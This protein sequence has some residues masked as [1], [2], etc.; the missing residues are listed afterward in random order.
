MKIKK[1]VDDGY[2]FVVVGLKNPEDKKIIEGIKQKALKDSSKVNKR[3]PNNLARS[4]ELIYWNNLGGILAENVVK[5][6]LNDLIREGNINA[7]ILEEEFTTHEDHRD[8]KIRVGDIIKTIEVRSSFNYLAS[9][10]GVLSGKFSLIGQYTTDYKKTEPEKDFYITVIHR[11][12]NEEIISRI[13]K[14]VEVFIIGGA[15]KEDFKNKGREDNRKLKQGNASYIIISPI[16]SA[17]N[18]PKVFSDILKT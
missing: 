13:N 16:S 2:I 7:K 17:D 3:S 6:Y 15:S 11:Y 8:I 5:Y 10:K 12:K 14:E 18:V 9:L 4:P 1:E